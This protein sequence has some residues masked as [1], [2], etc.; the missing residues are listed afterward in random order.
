MFLVFRRIFD[1]I[2]EVQVNVLKYVP[3]KVCNYG[4]IILNLPLYLNKQVL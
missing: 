1:E 3:I 2:V 4:I